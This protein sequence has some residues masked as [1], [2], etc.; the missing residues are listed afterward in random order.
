MS[1]ASMPRPQ[2]RPT[3]V[4]RRLH[5]EDRLAADAA[6]GDTGPFAALYE[7]HHRSLYRYCRSIAREPDDAADVL[8]K[9]DDAG[10][11]RDRLARPCGS[12]AS[13]AVQDRVQPAVLARPPEDD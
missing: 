10:A 2:W 3:A 4:P 1:E 9:H 11:R 12:R 7:R 8:Q 6:K 5:S 13:L